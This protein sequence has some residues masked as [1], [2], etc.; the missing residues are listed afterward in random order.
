MSS[1]PPN[2]VVIAPTYYTSMKDGR[3]MLGLK[4]CEEAVRQGMHLILVDASPT[5]DIRDKL[6][7]SGTMDGKAYVDVLVQTFKGKKGA[8]LREAVAAA[9]RKICAE[10]NNDKDRSREA[11]VCFQEPE[12]SDMMRQWKTI[13]AHM[14]E[15]KADICVPCRSDA[16]F[17]ETYPK[18]QYHSETFGNMYLDTLAKAAEFE[19]PIDWLMGPIAWRHKLSHLWTEYEDGDLWDAQICP[20]VYAKRWHGAKLSSCQIDYAHPPTLKEE[21]EGSPMFIEKRLKQLNIVFDHVGKAL[22]EDKEEYEARTQQKEKS[23]QS[24][25]N[26]G[27]NKRQKTEN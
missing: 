24:K 14:V 1:D 27:S 8:A 23:I 10:W 26:G 11:I 12:K 22:K 9:G 16:S 3:F 2:I 21:E 18:E 19:Q 15:N 4:T 17:K 13:V 6:R 20:M 5:E 25:E 7:A